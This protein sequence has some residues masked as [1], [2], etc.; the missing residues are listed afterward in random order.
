MAVA[1]K[2]R[3]REDVWVEI[4]MLK[5]PAFA[6]DELVDALGAER[7]LYGSE[8]PVYYPESA[9][10]R[11]LTGKLDERARALVMRENA[12]KAFWGRA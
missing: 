8:A 9:L 2:L 3:A 6:V 5:G 10:E 11:V 4:A 1:E 7:V 12:R